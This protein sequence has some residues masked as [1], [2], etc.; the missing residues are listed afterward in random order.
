MKEVRLKRA[1]IL[2]LVSFAVLHGLIWWQLHD[3]VFR[4][5]GDFASFYTAGKIVQHG[6]SARLYDRRLQWQ[7]QQEFASSVK[8]RRAPLPYVRPPFEALWFLPFAYLNYPTALLVWTAVK[9][10]ALLGVPFLLAQ[11]SAA[12]SGLPLRPWLQGLLCLGFCPVA[13]DLLQGQDSILLLLVLTLVFTSLRRG[14]DFRSGIY[15]GLGL[16]KFHLVVPMFVV[17]LLKRRTRAV[18]GF[19]CVASGWLLISLALVGRSGLIA[20]PEYLWSLNQAPDVGIN[21]SVMPNI[22]GL[23]TPFTG[24]ER[25]PLWALGALLSVL[26]LGI[27]SMAT[28]W[29]AN[30][31]GGLNRAGFSFCIVV[32]LVTSYYTAGYDLTLLILPLLLTGGIF[33]R[34]AGIWGWPRILYGAAAA[35]LLCSP[36]YWLLL[37]V[38]EFFRM[39]L[40]LLALIISL[41]TFLR[42]NTPQT[43]V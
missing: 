36:L 34:G 28:M 9:I 23:L 33:A 18:L 1:L 27:L 41:S 11:G 26:A 38:N 42:E 6:E 15:L 21:S 40:V 3:S 31:D 14:A 13:L 7:V 2:A 29:P 20:Y 39:A 10:V 12:D 5:Y 24:Q 19:L 35:L 30:E 22:R 32:T 43:L 8:I 4:G 16:F 37:S 17:L 25:V